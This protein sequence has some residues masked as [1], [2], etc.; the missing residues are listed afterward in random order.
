MS[1]DSSVFCLDVPAEKFTLNGQ[2]LNLYFDD[3]AGI[4]GDDENSPG[5]IDVL[6][7]RK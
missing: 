2:N 1:E 3:L 5:Y 7:D 6:I 4:L